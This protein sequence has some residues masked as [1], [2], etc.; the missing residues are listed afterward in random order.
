VKE[1][2]TY[3]AGTV[4]QEKMTMKEFSTCYYQTFQK[5]MP[6]ML[7]QEAAECCKRY[8]PEVIRAAFS[9]TAEAGGSNFSY[10]KK[11]LENGPRTP[12]QTMDEILNELIAKDE[13]NRTAE[14][15][16]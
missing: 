2:E 1:I 12:K 13:A 4:I 8:P 10:T 7:N 5:L 15:R 6:G 16:A 14:E 3:E 9:V 11:V